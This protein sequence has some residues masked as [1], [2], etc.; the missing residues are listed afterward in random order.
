MTPTPLG[1]PFVSRLTTGV[2]TA[3]QAAAQ[4]PLD[5]QAWPH[6]VALA[7]EVVADKPGQVGADLVADVTALGHGENHVQVL[8]RAALGLLDEGEHEYE[9]EQVESRENEQDTGISKSVVDSTWGVP[10][11]LVRD[12]LVRKL[13]WGNRLRWKRNGQDASK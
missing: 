5:V 8:K 2:V 11:A 9:G 3:V 1:L 13:V 7:E 4:V 12:S 10:N 6:P